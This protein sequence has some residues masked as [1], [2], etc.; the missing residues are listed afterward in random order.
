[1][2]LDYPITDCKSMCAARLIILT[3][4]AT[5]TARELYLRFPS[6]YKML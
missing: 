4:F 2:L 1:M 3:K 5:M 6:P